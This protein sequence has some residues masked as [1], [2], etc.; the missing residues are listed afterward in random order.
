MRSFLLP[1]HTF[2]IFPVI[3]YGA[4]FRMAVVPAM[5]Q[6]LANVRYGLETFNRVFTA[7]MVAGTP[8]SGLSVGWWRWVS[9]SGVGLV[10]A[11]LERVMPKGSDTQEDEPSMSLLIDG[12]SPPRVS[13]ADD[14]SPSPSP[15][16]MA[17][18]KGGLMLIETKKLK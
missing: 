4:A 1:V 7:R 6:L 12:M 9:D 8:T 14:S 17:I 10:R 18:K 3:E 16:P 11:V 2:I 5:A 15:S 13:S